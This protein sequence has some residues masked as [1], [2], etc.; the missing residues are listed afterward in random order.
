MSLSISVLMSVI[1]GE[2]VMPMPSLVSALVVPVVLALLAPLIPVIATCYGLDRA[3]RRLERLAVRDVVIRDQAAVLAMVAVTA[4]VIMPIWRAG[5]WPLGLGYLRNLMGCLGLA[6]LAVPMLGARLAALP[7]VAAVIISALLG[8]GMGGAAKWWAWPIADADSWWA[9]LS[10]VAIL[11][12]GL[13]AYR[14]GERRP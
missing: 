6:L 13:V 10:G 2:T 3:V 12:V 11:A 8:T 14:V 7:P 4:A 1:L 9:F 5:I